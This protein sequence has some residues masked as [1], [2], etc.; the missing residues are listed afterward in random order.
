MDV[1]LPANR[2]HAERDRGKD[3]GGVW[4]S[5]GETEEAVIAPA[6]QE[7]TCQHESEEQSKEKERTTHE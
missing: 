2:G 4:G 1:H 6:Q 7:A 3:N 5:E